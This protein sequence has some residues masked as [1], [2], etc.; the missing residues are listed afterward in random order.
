MA[1][2]IVPAWIGA[3][4]IFTSSTSFANPAITFARSLSE[5]FAGISI[6]SVPM[7]IFAQCIGALLG[8]LLAAIL[9]TEKKDKNVIA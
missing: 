7:F 8:V 6:K 4:Y 2:V 9:T 5:S 3:A 1:A